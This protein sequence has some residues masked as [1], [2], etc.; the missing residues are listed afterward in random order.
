MKTSKTATKIGLGCVFVIIFA[1]PL[2]YYGLTRWLYPMT[3]EPYFN[4]ASDRAKLRLIAAIYDPVIVALGEHHASHG[5]FPGDLAELHASTEGTQQARAV[6]AGQSHTVYY[7]VNEGEFMLHV[8]LNWDG[9][10]NYSSGVRHWRYDPGNGDPDW[11]I[12]PPST[13]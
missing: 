5:T 10:L 6:L 13:N 11:S 3:G 12:R 8:K 7:Q 1:A 2:A 9:G 4:N